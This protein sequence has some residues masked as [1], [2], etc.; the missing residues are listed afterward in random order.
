M[1]QLQTTSHSLVRHGVALF[2][3]GLVTGTQQRRFTNMRMALSAHLEGV[4]NGTF[5][6]ALGAIW[7]HVDLPPEV[8]PVARWTTLYGTYGNWLFTALGAALGTAAANP[9]L[10]QGHH[11]TAWQ[12]RIVLLGF[13]SMRYAF[14]TAVAL[15]LLGIF[16]R[17]TLQD[18]TVDRVNEGERQCV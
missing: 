6:M 15:I 2:F 1:A 10:S 9:T 4:M 13:R 16:R 18:N 14:L 17:N 3:L 12:E 5:L 8:E 7:D 11:G